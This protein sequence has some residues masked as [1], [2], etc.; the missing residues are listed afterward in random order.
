MAEG[1][2]SGDSER[3]SVLT[4]L[5]AGIVPDLEPVQNMR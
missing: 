5:T 3:V 4:S 1:F 2:S